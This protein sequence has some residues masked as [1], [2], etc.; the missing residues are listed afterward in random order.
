MGKSKENDY[1]NKK[2]YLKEKKKIKKLS[3]ETSE[4]MG[5]YKN[6]IEKKLQ[7]S[8]NGYKSLKENKSIEQMKSYYNKK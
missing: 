6:E 7:N 3:P 4:L 8:V 5:S 2:E 1:F